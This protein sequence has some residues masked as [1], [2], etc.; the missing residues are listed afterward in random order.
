MNEFPKVIASLSVRIIRMLS[1]FAKRQK[2]TR[3]TSEIV[4]YFVRPKGE[5]F[6]NADV[7]YFDQVSFCSFIDHALTKVDEGLYGLLQVRP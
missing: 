6:D 2:Q 1:R 3:K 4:A 7:E 5:E